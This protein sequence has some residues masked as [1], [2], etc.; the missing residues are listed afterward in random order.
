[1]NGK[2]K[3]LANMPTHSYF[4]KQILKDKAFYHVGW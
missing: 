4:Q 3:V 2:N 1:M